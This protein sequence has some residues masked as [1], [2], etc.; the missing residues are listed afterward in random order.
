MY[1]FA[2]LTVPTVPYFFHR[3]PLGQ[4]FKWRSRGDNNVG[5]NRQRVERG[6]RDCELKASSARLFHHKTAKRP[7][8]SFLLRAG[9]KMHRD[10]DGDG[11]EMRDEKSGEA[12]RRKHWGGSQ[13]VGGGKKWENRQRR[14]QKKPFSSHAFWIVLSSSASAES[15]VQY[16]KLV[17]GAIVFSLS[18]L[19]T[20]TSK[21]AS[22]QSP[23]RI[24]K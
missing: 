23:A 4:H 2:N 22:C 14:K 21:R 3:P 9:W 24:K 13:R 19:Q 7:R 18:P 5:G 10:R 11:L 12:Q 20:H 8:P 6:D 17:R 15:R 16:L 1:L